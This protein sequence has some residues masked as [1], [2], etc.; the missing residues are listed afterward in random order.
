MVVWS[1]GCICHD[2]C[3]VAKKPFHFTFIGTNPLF[4]G[5]NFDFCSNQIS[6]H[7][8]QIANC[9][10]LTHTYI[11]NFTKQTVSLGNF[12]KDPWQYLLQKLNRALESGSLILKRFVRLKSGKSLLE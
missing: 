3:I 10:F 8:N 1:P 5:N 11:C 2:F 6:Y 7:L 12:K 9:N 4:V